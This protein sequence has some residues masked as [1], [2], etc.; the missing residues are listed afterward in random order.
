MDQ[1]PPLPDDRY[2]EDEPR[3]AYDVGAGRKTLRVI[4]AVAIP[5]VISAVVGIGGALMLAFASDSKHGDMTFAGQMFTG[6]LISVGAFALCGIPAA[7]AV[8]APKS[9]RGMWWKTCFAIAG[10]S[11]LGAIAC[12]VLYMREMMT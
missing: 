8:V 1:P 9:R 5:P 6:F 12:F 3:D 11:I 7:F 10:L 4:A 2:D